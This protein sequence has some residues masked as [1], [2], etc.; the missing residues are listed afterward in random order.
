MIVR[1]ITL[2]VF[3]SPLQV[4]CTGYSEMKHYD[5]IERNS[6]LSEKNC[7]SS[8]SKKKISL[9]PACIVWIKFH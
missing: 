4:E 3:H 7:A 1:N 6:A 5:V 9:V 8:S 2:S